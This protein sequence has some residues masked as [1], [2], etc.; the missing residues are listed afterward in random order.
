MAPW[1]KD[2]ISTGSP[3]MAASSLR[4]AEISSR[5]SSLAGTTRL[6]PMRRRYC[7]ASEDVTDIWVL[8]CR[9]RPGQASRRAATTPRSW[10]ITPS[11]PSSQRDL[12]KSVSSPSSSSRVRTLAVR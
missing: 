3:L 11:R 12:T 5:D 2:S 10:M 1:I 8:A 7:T 4:R 6:I 9:G